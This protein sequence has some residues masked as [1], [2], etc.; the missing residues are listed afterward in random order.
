MGNVVTC[1]VCTDGKMRA[2]GG[3][4]NPISQT[5]EMSDFDEEGL[6]IMSSIKLEYRLKITNLPILSY[7][8]MDNKYPICFVV[9]Y[10]QQTFKWTETFPN[11]KKTKMTKPLTLNYEIGTNQKVI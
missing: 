10:K 3:S 5:L 1:A 2:M 4:L 8:E 11:T 6:G 7:T 9:D